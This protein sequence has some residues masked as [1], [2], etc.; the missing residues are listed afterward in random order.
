MTEKDDLIALRD[1]VQE[2]KWWDDES[3]AN[4]YCAKF[5]LEKYS[6]YI[7]RAMFGSV[8]AALAFLDAV[9]QGFHPGMSRNIHTE[10]WYAWVQTKEKHFDSYEETPARALLIATLNALIAEEVERKKI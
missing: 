6:Y 8:D 3:I 5:G 10:Y 4:S 9:L 2:G 7:G 1:T